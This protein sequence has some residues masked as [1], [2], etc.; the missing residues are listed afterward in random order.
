MCVC[1]VD[2]LWGGVVGEVCLDGKFEICN[3]WSLMVLEKELGS[4][5]SLVL[6]SLQVVR[7]QE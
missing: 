2:I 1:Q 3:F 5:V 6:P 7:C 4:F